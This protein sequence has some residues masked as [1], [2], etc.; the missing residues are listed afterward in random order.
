PL[1]RAPLSPSWPRSSAARVTSSARA[2]YALANLGARAES[3][4]RSCSTSTWPSQ[5]AP[6]PMPIV[7]MPSSAVI[8]AARPSGMPSR[9][10]GRAPGAARGRDAFE[11]DRGGAGARGGGR[12]FGDPSPA[13][14]R[15]SLAPALHL[16]AAHAV[17]R[18]RRETGGAHHRHTTPRVV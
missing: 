11:H 10:N 4:S 6:A 8:S 13:A 3:P 12:V 16:V 9:T 7:G 2:A 1:G 18:L 17:D 14:G 15:M 5:K